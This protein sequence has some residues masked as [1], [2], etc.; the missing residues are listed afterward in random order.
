MSRTVKSDQ[1][2]EQFNA[3]KLAF[4]LRVHQLLTSGNISPTQCT[5]TYLS[6]PYDLTVNQQ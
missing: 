3:L 5:R 6:V 4:T 1:S 2:P